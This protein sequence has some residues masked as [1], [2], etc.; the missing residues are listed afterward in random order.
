VT[1][2]DAVPDVWSQAAKVNV[3]V[4]PSFPS[5]TYRTCEVD[6]SSRTFVAVTAPTLVHVTPSVE[7]CHAPFPVFLLMAIPLTAPVST[8]AQELEVKIEL[9]VVPD[10]AVFSSVPANVTVAPFVIVG[11]SLMLL[12]VM[13]AV[14]D[15]L[16]YAVVPPPLP[17]FA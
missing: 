17:G 12:T 13:D 11:A 6:V 10:E 1:F 5:G 3:A 8:S 14:A 9:T 16:L 15:W 7:Y 4:S 2:V